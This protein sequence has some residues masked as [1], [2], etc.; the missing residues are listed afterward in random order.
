MDSGHEATKAKAGEPA[1]LVLALIA[2][3]MAATRIGDAARMLGYGFVQIDAPAALPA[4]LQRARPAMVVLDLAE[5]RYAASDVLA[6]LAAAFNQPPP[7]LAFYPHV[8]RELGQSGREAGIEVVVPRS[9][10]M[11][12][13]PALLRQMVEDGAAGVTAEE[14]TARGSTQRGPLR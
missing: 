6:A 11:N 5:G 7:V 3:L 2:D 8:R 12:D 13:L 1:P 14:H 9:R 10:F 4:L